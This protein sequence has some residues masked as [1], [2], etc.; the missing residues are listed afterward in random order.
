VAEK[1]T[2]SLF[3]KLGAKP[4]GADKPLAPQLPSFASSVSFLPAYPIKVGANALPLA[5]PDLGALELDVVT[6]H[7]GDY[8]GSNDP[9][10]KAEDTEEPVPVV[11]PAI[12][13]GHV[14]V[15]A[16][17]PL[18]DCSG[19]LLKQARTWLLGGLATF[20]LGAKTNSG[21]GWFEDVTDLIRQ[22]QDAV[23]AQQAAQERQRKEQADRDAARANLQPDL[24]V[25]E[26]LRSLKD[27]DLRG[28]INP[29]ATE[30]RFWTQKDERVQL[31]VLHFLGVTAPDLLAADRANPKSK[32]AKAI[33]NLAAKFPHVASQKP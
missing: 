4:H 18:R 28:Q 25:I 9:D 5:E 1:A 29:F 19:E 12:A 6:C 32:I 11:F 17:L 26:K 10:A 21:Y 14:F 31:T 2:A 16:M 27:P 15:F 24:E 8:Y 13:A 7:H 20:G 3:K 22:A 30:E 23:K 33:A